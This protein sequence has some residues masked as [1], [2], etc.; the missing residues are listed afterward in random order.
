MFKDSELRANKWN[1]RIDTKR[2]TE[3]EMCR[4]SSN[5]MQRNR[6]SG[7]G[8]DQRRSDIRNNLQ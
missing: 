5:I 2:L 8:I 1:R 6:N 7:K 4:L 3:Y